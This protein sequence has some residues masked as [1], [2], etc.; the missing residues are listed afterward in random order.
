MSQLIATA[1]ADMECLKIIKDDMSEL[2]TGHS[3]S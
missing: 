2:L 1:N 3:V